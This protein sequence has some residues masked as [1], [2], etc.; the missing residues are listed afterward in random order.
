MITLAYTLYNRSSSNS[1]TLAFVSITGCSSR[2]SAATYGESIVEN[3]V[4]TAPATNTVHNGWV[5]HILMSHD[6]VELAEPR[7]R[8]TVSR[9]FC[10]VGECIIVWGHNT[11]GIRY[12]HVCWYQLH[13]VVVDCTWLFC[14]LV[15]YI[16]DMFCVWWCPEENSPRI[17]E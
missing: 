12:N 1:C 5:W 7:I 9:L 4:P 16:L 17:L 14:K 6:R 15:V 13:L 2:L 11:Q 3:S 10:C 8:S